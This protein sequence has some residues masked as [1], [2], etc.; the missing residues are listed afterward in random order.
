MS[1]N[2][3]KVSLPA[4]YIILYSILSMGHNSVCEPFPIAMITIELWEGDEGKRKNG[5]EEEE[6]KEVACVITTC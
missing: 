2:A 1:T 6:R 4:F 5:K 3:L